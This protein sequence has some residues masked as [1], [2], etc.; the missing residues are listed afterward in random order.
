MS[1]LRHASPEDLQLYVIDALGTTSKR[2]LEDHV[3]ACDGCARSLAQE[4][5]LENTLAEL[6]PAVRRPLAPVVVLRAREVPAEAPRPRRAPSIR[7]PSTS[8]S[9]FAAAAVALLL[10]GWW[11][12]GSRPGAPVVS[13]SQLICT[14]PGF[15]MADAVSEEGGVCRASDSARLLCTPRVAVC[16][17]LIPSEE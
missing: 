15:S 14:S 9:G 16:S 1:T 8:G 3:G 4:A 11:T 2:W 7:R 5:A 17:S 6:W 12:D 10:L 13:A